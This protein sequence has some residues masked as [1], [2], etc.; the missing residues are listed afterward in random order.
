MTDEAAPDRETAAVSPHVAAVAQLVTSTNKA[1]AAAHQ[2]GRRV[3]ARRDR[4]IA[5]AL[6]V[7]ARRLAR[8]AWRAADAGRRRMQ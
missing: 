6:F 2:H 7:V 5:A 1:I 8:W 4:M 3:I